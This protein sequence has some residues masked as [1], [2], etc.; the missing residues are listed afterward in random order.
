MTAILTFFYENGTSDFRID[1]HP[2]NLP[3]QA[4]ITGNGFDKRGIV[5]INEGEEIN[6]VRWAYQLVL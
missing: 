4:V 6:G 1:T 5:H 2:G 3:M